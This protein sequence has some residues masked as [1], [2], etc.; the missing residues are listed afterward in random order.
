MC[1]RIPIEATPSSFHIRWAVPSLALLKIPYMVEG[2]RSPPSGLRAATEL[3]NTTGARSPAS[4]AAT[5]TFVVPTTFTRAP[6]DGLAAHAGTWRAARWMT[7]PIG[8]STSTRLIVSGKGDVPRVLGDQ[9]CVIV[10]ED[11]RSRPVRILIEGH[12]VSLPA[13]RFFTTQAPMKP[14]AR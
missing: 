4:R 12:H 14:R 5:S 6:S 3:A 1:G 2:G 8:C 10:L 7:A 11:L 9:V 13:T